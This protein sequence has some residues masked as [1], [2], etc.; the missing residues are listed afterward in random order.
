M[1]AEVVTLAVPVALACAVGKGKDLTT[2]RFSKFSM[3]T[4]P[5]NWE[6]RSS[7]QRIGS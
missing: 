6:A 5:W 3:G 1:C 4:W 7:I 2:W